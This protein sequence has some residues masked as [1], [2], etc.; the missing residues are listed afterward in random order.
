MAASIPPTEA[1]NTTT[2]DL[3]VRAPPATA[4]GP[5]S[6]KLNIPL[7]LVLHF[8]RW[9]RRDRLPTEGAYIT[10]QNH[11]LARDR[12]VV[13]TNLEAIMNDPHRMN[14]GDILFEGTIAP[15]FSKAF[16]ELETLTREAQLEREKVADEKSVEEHLIHIDRLGKELDFTDA[17]MNQL[18]SG[19]YKEWKVAEDVLDRY[20]KI[21]S[22]YRMELKP[23]TVYSQYLDIVLNVHPGSN[24]KTPSA[25]IDMNFGNHL[26]I[27]SIG[28]KSSYTSS[29]SA[30]PI[31]AYDTSGSG[32]KQI[33]FAYFHGDP[34]DT[35]TRLAQKSRQTMRTGPHA[36]ERLVFL[37]EFW[38]YLAMEPEHVSVTEA[39]LRYGNEAIQQYARKRGAILDDARENNRAEN[40]QGRCLGR[41]L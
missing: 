37:E 20:K 2:T 29:I 40:A 23:G 41:L 15:D 10:I 39:V 13:P 35:L 30:Q 33:G 22:A 24:G 16:L 9:P 17:I 31:K 11:P 1:M 18:I 8:P 25:N 6:D 34:E 36:S 26:I 3:H 27:S 5:S 7:L 12:S 21:V 38:R 28:Y 4:A 32:R 19:D 14:I